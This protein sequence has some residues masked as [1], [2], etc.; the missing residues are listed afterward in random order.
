MEYYLDE[1]RISIN[2]ENFP[3]Y[4]SQPSKSSDSVIKDKTY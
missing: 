1:N 2:F 4:Y 3:K